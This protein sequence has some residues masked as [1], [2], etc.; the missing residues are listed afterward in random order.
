[1]GR[2]GTGIAEICSALIITHCNNCE[3]DVVG[4]NL[5][6]LIGASVVPRHISF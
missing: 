4:S 2:G 6:S 5:T 1:M 3:S